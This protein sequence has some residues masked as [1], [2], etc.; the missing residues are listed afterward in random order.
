MLVRAA[1]R[2]THALLSVKLALIT[3]GNRPF[4]TLD[5]PHMISCMVYEHSPLRLSHGISYRVPGLGS[6]IQF[7]HHLPLLRMRAPARPHRMAITLGDHLA[8][9]ARR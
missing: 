7:L 9:A 2:W 3:N 8:H 1:G 4:T 6:S 5:L